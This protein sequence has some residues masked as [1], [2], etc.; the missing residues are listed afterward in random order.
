MA[1]AH[2][3]I[4]G[5][6]S[7]LAT[8]ATHIRQLRGELARLGAERERISA[9]ASAA[10]GHDD[11]IGELKRTRAEAMAAALI[12]GGGP[13]DVA[14]ID[15]NISEAEARAR[16]A[17]STGMVA[18]DALNVIAARRASL[19]GELTKAV[20]A[21]LEVAAHDLLAQRIE[22]FAAFNAAANALRG[23]LERM[24]AIERTLIEVRRRQSKGGGSGAG[25][26][27][28]LVDALRDQGLR[29]VRE[30][31]HALWP[32]AWLSWPELAARS[33]AFSRDFLTNAAL[34]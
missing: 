32:C 28:N 26:A 21:Q 27:H 30:H 14:E 3:K 34:D 11:E 4:E 25:P 5:E 19:E 7:A 24:L 12:D 31:D 15:A 13:A 22:E 18:A 29:I 6:A 33:P 17:I 16:E 23:P 2:S 20:D 8:G 1:K 10:Q 9:L